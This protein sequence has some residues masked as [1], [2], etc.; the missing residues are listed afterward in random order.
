[1]TRHGRTES[2]SLS[3]LRNVVSATTNEPETTKKSDKLP[4]SFGAPHPAAPVAAQTNVADTSSRD[5]TP[6]FLTAACYRG[7]SRDRPQP[8]P[9]SGTATQRPGPWTPVTTVRPMSADLLGPEWSP[10]AAGRSA[11]RSSSAS[12]S[13]P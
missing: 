8:S 4:Q 10:T 12:S 13:R 5:R 7:P 11:A 9:P 3:S 2:R 6:A 1:M